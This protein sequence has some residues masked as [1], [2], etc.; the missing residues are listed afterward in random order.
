M[1]RNAVEAMSRIAQILVTVKGMAASCE[2]PLYRMIKEQLGDCQEIMA[3]YC[4]T[5]PFKLMS[6]QVDEIMENHE[7]MK[8]L[9]ETV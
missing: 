5:S 2:R 3:N 8:G 1:D 9:Q 7:Y 4:D 6:G